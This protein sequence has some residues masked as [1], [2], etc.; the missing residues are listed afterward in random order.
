MGVDSKAYIEG[1]GIN[2]MSTR[3]LGITGIALIGVW[4]LAQAAVALT[5]LLAFALDPESGSSL[6]ET[7]S[8]FQVLGVA[9]YA[10]VGILLIF[11]RYVLAKAWF[12]ESVLNGAPSEYTVSS[13]LFAV[14]GVWFMA[15]AAIDLVHHEA[16]NA[17]IAVIEGAAVQNSQLWPLRARALVGF[18]VG[19]GLFA[20]SEGLSHA[21]RWLRKAR[22]YRQHKPLNGRTHR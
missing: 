8:V 4:M 1:S 7:F 15:N 14:V 19:F 20:G 10:V 12:P 21:W 13:V 2:T 22:W 17:S 18:S 9:S 5:R 6:S 11:L 3:D 16:E